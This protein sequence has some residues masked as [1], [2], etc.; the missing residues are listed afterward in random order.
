MALAAYA[1]AVAD[2]NSLLKLN[3]CCSF[4]DP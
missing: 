2:V 3:H 4:A 1:T